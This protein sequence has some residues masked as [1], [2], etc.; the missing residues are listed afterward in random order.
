MDISFIIVNYKSEQ[1]LK[2]CLSSLNKSAPCEK[3]EVIVINNDPA[4]LSLDSANYELR[5]INQSKNI[6]FARACNAGAGYANGK[7]LFFL[8]PDTEILTPNI[9]SLIDAFAN[10]NIGIVA[11]RLVIPSGDTQMWSVGYE[12]GVWDIIKNNLGLIASRKLWLPATKP[13]HA[14][15]V[16]GGAFLMRKDFFLQLG[17]FDESF[18]M[19]FEDIDLCKRVRKNNKEILVLPQIVVQHL[20][21]QSSQC[22]LQ[23]KKQYYESQDHY[24]NK[25]AGYFEAAIIKTIRKFA[26]LIKK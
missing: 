19:Y 15:W 18:F 25:H 12:T 3:W 5:V 6:G 1:L 26:L 22:L 13:F 11:P 9:N 4:P 2:N 16:S 14:D 24:F 20:V 8:N 21:S 17:G 7:I 23:Q 10:E